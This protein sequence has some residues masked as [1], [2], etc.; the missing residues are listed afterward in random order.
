MT[1]FYNI[2]YIMAICQQLQCYLFMNDIIF[3]SVKV[4]FNAKQVPFIT[5]FIISN[6]QS[7]SLSTSV[8]SPDFIS[9]FFPYFL[10][11]N[12]TKNAACFVPEKLESA[13]FWWSNFPFIVRLVRDSFQKCPLNVYSAT[14]I[15]KKSAFTRLI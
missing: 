2:Y 11:L 13:F 9:L 7:M 10:E 4:K 6:K 3:Y 12:K 1:W 14:K 15:N 8:S 5:H